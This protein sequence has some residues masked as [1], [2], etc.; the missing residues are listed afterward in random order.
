MP[1]NFNPGDYVLVSH[2]NSAS[3]NPWT[4]W[5]IENID[6][7]HMGTYESLEEIY[8]GRTHV[9]SCEVAHIPIYRH[10]VNCRAKYSEA[11][12]LH[13]FPDGRIRRMGANPRLVCN[14]D[15]GACKKRILCAVISRDGDPRG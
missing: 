7:I 2:V 15:C 10:Q 5:C 1:K 6:E 4:P 3:R 12:T 13:T 9:G 11:I 14:L 8:D